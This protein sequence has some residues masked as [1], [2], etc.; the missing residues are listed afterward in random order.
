MSIV[1]GWVRFA[2]LVVGVAAAI[3][4]AMLHSFNHFDQVEERFA[5]VC[6]PVSGIAGPEDIQIDETRRRA[7]ISSLKRG[8][9]PG[10]RGAIY[11]LALDDPLADSNWRDRT[12]GAPEA[13]KPLGIH[14]YEDETARRLFVVNEASKSVELYDVAGNGDLT[15]L[16]TITERRLTSPNNIVATGPRSF[17]ISNDVEAGRSSMMGQ[18]NFLGRSSTGKI[19]FYDG[20]GWR[21]AADG[22]RFANGLA[23]SA[24][25]KTL[26]AAETSG[27]AIKVYA[28]DPASNLLT[29]KRTIALSASPDNLTLGSD[30]EIWIGALPKPLMTPSQAKN[31]KILSPSMVIRLRDQDGEPDLTEIFESAGAQISASTVAAVSEGQLL[32]GSLLED[33]FLLCD[34][35]G[36]T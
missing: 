19:L 30:N 7:F 34:L 2:V 15:H 33:K 22:L 8:A 35:G 3:V 9:T 23:L 20:Q 4:A 29:V 17:Y 6:A 16:E 13:F 14:F 10:E 26:Y 24:D 27:G 31:P 21:L 36:A 18:L 1:M 32:V 5:G 25:K 28:R 12:L 11:A